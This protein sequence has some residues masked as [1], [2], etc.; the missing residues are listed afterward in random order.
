MRK[1]ILKAPAKLNLFLNIVGK[2]DD[3]YHLLESIMQTIDLFDIVTVEERED[4]D[5][6]ISCDNKLVP[7][8]EKNIAYKIAQK[9]FE[10]KGI[11]QGL[12]IDIKKRIPVE[13]GMG[14]GS[15][16][17]AA[18]LVGLNS[19]FNLELSYEEMIKI[20]GTIGADIPFATFG[21]TALTEGIGEKVTRI[22][23]IS[24]CYFLIVKPKESINTKEA[25]KKIDEKNIGINQDIK[26]ILSGAEEKNNI[27][28]A[29]NMANI[30]EGIAAEGI[31][32]LKKEIK[33]SGAV[34]SIMTGSGSAVFGLFEDEKMAEES[35]RK[36]RN[37]YEEVF[38]CRPYSKGAAKYDFS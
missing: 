21:G 27:K 1:I 28:I 19:L 17:G 38:V 31:L 14:G 30:F 24:E 10:Y 32:N 7:C 8:D 6:C 20:G 5:I 37:I 34:N 4:R 36:F 16:D 3:G 9:V 13:A 22:N 11:F 33:A 29:E 2:R 35:A 12:N 25:F 15:A 18:T 23:D 26:H